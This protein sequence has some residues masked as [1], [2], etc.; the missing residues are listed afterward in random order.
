MQE[1]SVEVVTVLLAAGANPDLVDYAGFTALHIVCRFR[2]C[3]VS[4]M[5]T[6]STKSFSLPCVKKHGSSDI[7]SWLCFFMQKDFG[8]L[9]NALFRHRTSADK[10]DK[11]GLSALHILCLSPAVEV[12]S[13]IGSVACLSMVTQQ[14]TC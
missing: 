2:A 10:V 5:L 12:S 14:N 8:R 3:E 1:A 9:L 6:A 13:V 4:Y 7:Y 11:D